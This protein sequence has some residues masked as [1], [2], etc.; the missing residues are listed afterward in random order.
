[1]KRNPVFLFPFASLCVILIF[2]LSFFT[3]PHTALDNVAY[4]DK[5][6][7]LAMYGGTTAVFWLEYW[8]AYIKRSFQLGKATLIV[9]TFVMPTLLGGLI[10]LLQAYCTGGQRSGELLDWVADTLGVVVA[11]LMG[12]T[13]LKQLSM[14]IWKKKS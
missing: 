7:H 10:E 1:M 5:W 11:Y 9:L 13:L 8:H 12:V 3:P 6:T 4:I 14:K 2:I